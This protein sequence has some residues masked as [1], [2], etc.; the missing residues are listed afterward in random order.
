M[1]QSQRQNNIYW[2]HRQVSY[3][4]NG[5]HDSYLHPVWSDNKRD[6]GS[7]SKRLQ[8]CNNNPSVQ[9]LDK[10]SEQE[11]AQICLQHNGQCGVEGYQTIP[12]RWR[13]WHSIGGT[14]QPPCKCSGATRPN[15]KDHL[16]SGMCTA[17]KQFPSML[18]THM[19]PQA[20]DTLN[21]LQ[22][23]R[24]AHNFNRVRFTPPE[25]RSNI[26]DPL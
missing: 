14:K 11:R 3:L 7:A 18:W 21:M 19:I 26:F 17:D 6:F 4:I 10:I 2:L 15:F 13:H 8:K 16:I 9:R 12:T 22:T 20:Q 24:G 25:T 5:W 23:S 1:D